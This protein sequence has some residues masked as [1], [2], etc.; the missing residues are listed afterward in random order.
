MPFKTSCVSSDA[1][2]CGS[3]EVCLNPSG[4]QG[5]SSPKAF[6]LVKHTHALVTALCDVIRT[7]AT[8]DL[9]ILVFQRLS[10]WKFTVNSVIFQF[11]WSI[12]W[13]FSEDAST[14]LHFFPPFVA[15]TWLTLDFVSSPRAGVLQNHARRYNLPI[16]ELNFRFNMVPKYRDQMEV[17]EA[18]ANLPEDA[19]LE[20]DNEVL[21]DEVVGRWCGWRGWRGCVWSNKIRNGN[22]F[23]T[24]RLNWV[25][26]LLSKPLEVNS[27]GH[28]STSAHRLH[29]LLPKCTAH[30]TV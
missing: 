2:R 10:H 11:E 19:H 26:F 21:G 24:K 16:D 29:Q 4:S 5:S 18:L 3:L 27:R 23:I 30:C 20:M 28:Q 12:K 25:R 13:N 22:D 9:Y 8:Q 17:N 1:S 7:S 15:D 6:S 14:L